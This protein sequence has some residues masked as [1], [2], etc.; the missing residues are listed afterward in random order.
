MKKQICST[1]S[2]QNFTD[3]EVH[4][5]WDFKSGCVLAPSNAI[6][7]L[8]DPPL[9]SDFANVLCVSNHDYREDETPIPPIIFFTQTPAPKWD[10]EYMEHIIDCCEEVAPALH[11]IR[12]IEVVEKGGH[13]YNGDTDKTLQDYLDSPKI[14]A[15]PLHVEFSGVYE[16]VYKDTETKDRVNQLYKEAA[17]NW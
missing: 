16:I 13:F 14:L 1:K 6:A 12:E 17:G 9:D 10:R 2:T 4:S 15:H 3:I 5:K 7:A 8:V 11:K